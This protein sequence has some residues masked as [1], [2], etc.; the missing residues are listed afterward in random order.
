MRNA[1]F[2]MRITK[3]PIIL[4]LVL[5]A[6]SLS[7]AGQNQQINRKLAALEKLQGKFTFV[8]L[9]D[10]RSGDKEYSTL[11]SMAMARHPN[12]IVNVGD[13]IETPGSL[14]DW[15]KF[16]ELSKVVT[17]PYFLTVGNHD[18][19]PNVPLSE[20]TYKKQVDLPGN[21]LYYSFMAGN[22]LFI[23]LDSY[24]DD[25]E[26]KITGKQY[27]WL[28][29]VL[30]QSTPKH[31]FVFVHHPLYQEEGKGLHYG[32][33]LDKYPSKRDKLQALL[34]KHKVTVVFAG[35]NHIYLRK[36][37]DG[38]PHIITGGGGAPLH[39]D[40]KNGGFFHFIL[41]T[42]DGDK[43]NAEVVDINGKVRDRF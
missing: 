5:V 11:A 30:A 40:D 4:L 15:A 43:V 18:A 42:V 19:H 22:S 2:G 32:K 29:G 38:I 27:E 37:V 39:A 20:N 35:H 36:T 16:W 41:M 10:N 28:E 1:E 23:V 26:Q 13:Q 31:A 6:V 24:L 3:A 33:G 34:V 7:F 12:F 9:G 8:V 14:D 17:V 21:K 25:E